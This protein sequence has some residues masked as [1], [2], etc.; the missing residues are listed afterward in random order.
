MLHARALHLVL[1]TGVGNPQLISPPPISSLSALRSALRSQ[2][3]RG[4]GAS[5][6]QAMLACVRSRF[7][8][9][10]ILGD[11]QHSAHGLPDAFDT[12]M[13]GLHRMLPRMDGAQ[14]AEAALLDSQLLCKTQWPYTPMQNTIPQPWMEYEWHGEDPE[15]YRMWNQAL[16]AGGSVFNHLVLP[17]P[18]QPH[19]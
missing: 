17:P 15:L 11:V 10:S 14:Q 2:A 12:L 9:S 6:A 3:E 18:S 7:Y 1:S 5:G 4:G 8:F 13:K 19:T 16:P